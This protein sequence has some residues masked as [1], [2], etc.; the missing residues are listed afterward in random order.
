MARKSKV[1]LADDAKGKFGSLALIMA[2]LCLVGSIAFFLSDDG[3]VLGM[4][5]GKNTDIWGWLL[6]LV[7][8]FLAVTGLSIAVTM[9][10]R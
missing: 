10:K 3:S 9:S 1:N 7:S 4:D 2:A 8:M 5:I 6:M